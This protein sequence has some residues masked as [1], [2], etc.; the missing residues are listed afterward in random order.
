MK[1]F[2]VSIFAILYLGL[3]TGATVHMHFCMGKLVG[4]DLWHSEQSGVCGKCGMEKTNSKNKC[5]KDEHKVVKIVQD[6]KVADAAYHAVQLIP[7][8]I[9]LN[10]F[11]IPQIFV[12]SSIEENPNSN[13]PPLDY[14]VPIYIRNCVFRI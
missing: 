11:S 4:S 13:A 9:L 5:C 12:S 6:Q 2:I 7:V 10:H 8:E 14:Q 3:S 1:K